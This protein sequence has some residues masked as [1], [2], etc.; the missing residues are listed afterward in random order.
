M[1]PY[2]I[3]DEGPIF[4]NADRVSMFDVDETLVRMEHQEDGTVKIVPIMEHVKLLKEFAARDFFIVVWSD[5]GAEWAKEV[6]ELLNLT[7]FVDL[8]LSK[9][10]WYIDD[11][12]ANDWV[13]KRVYK[14]PD[15]HVMEVA[16]KIMEENAEL[17]DDLAKGPPC[18]DASCEM[19]GDKKN[20]T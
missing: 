10:L 12:E 2:E 7:N 19:C 3:S 9:P 1:R 4:V 16:Q 15:P 14:L 17:F 18:G 11:R 8:V 6:V 20:E 5:G 13:M